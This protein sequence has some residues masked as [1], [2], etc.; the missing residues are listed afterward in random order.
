MSNHVEAAT[1]ASSLITIKAALRLPALRRGAPEVL[2]GREHLDR[3]IRW[4]FETHDREL[5]ARDFE[6]SLTGRG[7]EGVRRQG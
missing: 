1:T 4:Y 6:E 3:T 5:L 2:A 7:F